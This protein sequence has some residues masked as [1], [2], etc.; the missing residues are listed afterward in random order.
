VKKYSL[1]SQYMLD[2]QMTPQTIYLKDYKA[3]DFYVDHVALEFDLDATC[4]RVTS[5]LQLRRNGEHDRPLVLDGSDTLKLISVSADMHQLADDKL[6]VTDSRNQFELHIVTEIDPAANTQLMGL[7]MSGGI[8]CTQC[9]AEGF[10][11]ITYFLDRPDVMAR[12]HV[13]VRADKTAFPIL[14]SNGNPGAMS[15]LPDGRHQAVWDDPHPKPCYLFALVAGDLHSYS[16]DFRTAE[17]RDVQLAIWVSKADVPRCAHAMESLKR[18]MRW[19]EE[20]FGRTYD[21]DVFNIVAVA[22]FNFGAMENKGLN[23]FNSKYILADANT[24]T[25]NDFDAIEAIVAHEYFHNWSGNRVT[26]RDWF[27]LSLKEG[28]TVY[29]DQDYSADQGSRAVKRIEDVRTLRLGQ[30]V[31]D[32]SPLAHSVRP[33][34][35]ME[36]SN[37]YTATVYNKGAEVI[38]MMHTLLGPE[39]FRAGCDLYFARH[40]GEAVTC[41][42]FVAAM[43]AASGTD[44]AQFKLWYAQAGTPRLTLRFAHDAA[45]RQATLHVSQHV[46]DTAGQNNKASMYMPLAVALF[47]AATGAKCGDDHVLL[48]SKA[49]ESFTLPA[50]TAPPVWSVLRNFTAPVTIEAD[51]PLADLALLAAHDDD[52]FARYEALQSLALSCLDAQVAAYGKQPIHVDPLL[53]EAMRATLLGPQDPAYK[54]LALALPS[55]SYIG[56]RMS[57]V[58]VDAIHAVRQQFRKHIGAVLRE[59]WWQTYQ[60]HADGQ[61]AYTPQAKG[62]RALKSQALAFLMVNDDAAATEAAAAQFYASDNMTDRMSA[63]AV[64]CDSNAPQRSDVLAYF[65]ETW[66]HD[67]NVLDKWFSLQAL[68]HHSETLAH[69]MQL[70][71]HPDF[72]LHN[73]NRLRALVGAFSM[74]QVRFHAADGAGYRFLA[75]QVLAVDKLNP[76]TAARLV[77]PLGRWRRFDAGRGQQMRQQ[78]ERIKKVSDLS[79]DVLELVTK[80]LD[81]D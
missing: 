29:R 76:Q 67:A 55:E 14:L 27:Q 49:E 53:I 81:A 58:A 60:A 33:A 28:F 50:N 32:A 10:R 62:R 34:S 45:K 15:D 68:S 9:E 40:D 66:R 57:T 48:L 56:Q 44:L 3:P 30:F 75:D 79:K 47:D 5:R 37:F 77:A 73:P 64:L 52:A 69:V 80:S 19:D 74:N 51:M 59:D 54:A 43:E 24:A 11:R 61:Y 4:T 25:D 12:Y 42:D 36:I 31:E 20:V 21:L 71:H 72:S 39:K 18:S 41:D 1:E 17:G 26:C 65:Y 38:R 7:Y 23:I 35:Y 78:L 13:V 22:D 46:P 6:I 70:A 8:F 63:L 16:D 2:V